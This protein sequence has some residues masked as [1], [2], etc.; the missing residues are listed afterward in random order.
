MHFE[1][2]D[3]ESSKIGS[4]TLRKDDVIWCQDIPKLVQSAQDKLEGVETVY[5]FKTRKKVIK[6]QFKPFNPNK[7]QQKSGRCNS[8]GKTET[9]LHDAK[10]FTVSLDFMPLDRRR[11]GFKDLTVFVQERE[12]GSTLSSGRSENLDRFKPSKLFH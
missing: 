7:P 1:H 10:K 11:I 12:S 3:K 6:R 9:H 5:L 4:P 2:A 8:Q